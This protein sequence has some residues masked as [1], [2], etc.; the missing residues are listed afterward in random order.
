MTGPADAQQILSRSNSLQVLEMPL[1]LLPTNDDNIFRSSGLDLTRTLSSMVSRGETGTSLKMLDLTKTAIDTAPSTWSRVSHHFFL[2]LL[3]LS[4]IL[5]MF[6][7]LHLHC[8]PL[9]GSHRPNTRKY[10][11]GC[12]LAGCFQH[13]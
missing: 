5:I 13:W 3:S 4:R 6:T 2:S 12:Q 11:A 7:L 1:F 10:F 8:L 9:F